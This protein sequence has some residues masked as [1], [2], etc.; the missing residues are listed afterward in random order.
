LIRCRAIFPPL[1][2]AVFWTVANA[3]I[4]GNKPLPFSFIHAVVIALFVV[5]SAGC[6]LVLSAKF[7]CFCDSKAVRAQD[8]LPEVFLFLQH[9]A[10][11]VAGRVLFAAQNFSADSSARL[12]GI[13][14]GAFHRE[15][16]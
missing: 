9:H 8:R 11:A 7:R 12:A 6:A 5:A 13:F 15:W 3:A 14:V 16:F 10:P 4:I 1:A 2:A